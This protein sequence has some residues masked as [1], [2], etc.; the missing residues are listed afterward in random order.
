MENDLSARLDKGVT[1]GNVTQER[2]DDVKGRL[3]ERMA[4]PVTRHRLAGP[5]NWRARSRAADLARSKGP[6]SSQC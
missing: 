3:P 1:D 2:T 4:N 5:N 6:S